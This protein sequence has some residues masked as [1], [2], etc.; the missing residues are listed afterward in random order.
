[1]PSVRVKNK[2]Y[3]SVH[4]VFGQ[5]D[6]SDVTQAQGSATEGATESRSLFPRFSHS[7]LRQDR[8]PTATLQIPG[9]PCAVTSASRVHAHCTLRNPRLSSS[10]PSRSPNSPLA[11]LPPSEPGEVRESNRPFG[12]RH[13]RSRGDSGRAESSINL[14]H[15]GTEDFGEFLGSDHHHDDVVEH[16]DVIG[17]YPGRGYDLDLYFDRCAGRCILDIDKCRQRYSH[18]RFVFMIL[19]IPSTYLSM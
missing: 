18:V 15:G 19:Q 10:T 2:T 6:P 5:A 14:S 4:D 11:P 7:F 16:L 3:T 9:R 17:N 1:M 13:I 8:T 12:I